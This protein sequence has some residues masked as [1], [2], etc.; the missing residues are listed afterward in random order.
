M[1]I[2]VSFMAYRTN[3]ETIREKA[4]IKKT[5]KENIYTILVIDA[6]AER[7]ITEY[8]FLFDQVLVT[9]FPQGFGQARRVSLLLGYAR[10]VEWC[11]VG[12][13]DEQYSPDTLSDFIAALLHAKHQ[14]DIFLPQ[15]TIVSLP[16]NPS[17]DKLPSRRAL[18][19]FENFVIAE[20]SGQS[21]ARFLDLQTGLYAVRSYLVPEIVKE[22]TF[23]DF[24]WDLDFARWFLSH[25]IPYFPIE[26]RT[27]P[28]TFSNYQAED[29]FRKIKYLLT[30]INPQDLP[31][32][33]QQW[34]Q[35]GSKRWPAEINWEREASLILEI[36]SR[37]IDTPQLSA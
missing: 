17:S 5:L 31:E 27:R 26:T 33:V 34:K 35:E 2:S 28:Q 10:D 6:P 3:S 8:T 32:L 7:E 13:A 16:E 12:D 18:E 20:V 15:R 30:L 36:A 4:S 25:K 23:S 1:K 22:V 11:V 37:Y 14:H 9:Q 21:E 19:I 24:R 29:T